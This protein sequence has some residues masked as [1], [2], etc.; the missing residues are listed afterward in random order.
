[1]GSVWRLLVFISF[2]EMV[3]SPL[4]KN[5]MK[6]SRYLWVGLNRGLNNA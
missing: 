3:V 6:V 5:G 2:F 4:L 1:M